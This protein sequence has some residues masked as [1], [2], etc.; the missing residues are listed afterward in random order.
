M[1][2]PGS[3][4]DDF[5]TN[6]SAIEMRI[7]YEHY[8]TLKNKNWQLGAYLDHGNFSTDR[9]GVSWLG[10]EE[11]PSFSYVIWSSLG[12]TGKYHKA[13]GK[14]WNLHLKASLPLVA[15]TERPSY[16]FAFPED[17][18][19]WNDYIL[20]FQPGYFERA[21]FQTFTQFTNLQ[22]QSGLQHRIG[23]RGSSIGLN[24]QWSYL[25]AAGVKPLFRYNHHFTIVYQLSF[26]KS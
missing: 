4:G 7:F 8:R 10:F 6:V 2:A 1:Q 24:Y 26:K 13:L 3:W 15:F 17:H 11:D 19:D 14:N 5:A 23:K 12:V 20:L 9:Y 22:L 25:F 16:A 18:Y 21:Q